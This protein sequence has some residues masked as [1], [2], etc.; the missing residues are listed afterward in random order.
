MDN[1]NPSENEYR[2]VCSYKDCT[3]IFYTKR[4]AKYCG[5]CKKIHETEQSRVRNA[6]KRSADAK[7]Q[8]EQ[9]K[10]PKMKMIPM[11]MASLKNLS[12]ICKALIIETVDDE[13][14]CS[15]FVDHAHQVNSS[16][17]MQRNDKVW[18]TLHNASQNWSLFGNQ[19]RYRA[20]LPNKQY[21]IFDNLYTR[22]TEVTSLAK[23]LREYCV[24][25][26]LGQPR[27]WNAHWAHVK[28]NKEGNLGDR[29]YYSASLETHKYK[30]WLS[31]FEDKFIEPILA[32]YPRHE[33]YRVTPMYSMGRNRNPSAMQQGLLLYDLFNYLFLITT[34]AWHS[35]F[36][37]NGQ[38]RIPGLTLG[39]GWVLAIEEGTFIH[40]R[41]NG[42]ES[43]IH[44]PVGHIFLFSGDLLHGGALYIDSNIR[45]HGYF[46]TR[47]YDMENLYTHW[48]LRDDD[49]NDEDEED[50]NSK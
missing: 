3:E 18:A 29:Y 4:A 23:H 37:Q 31:R 35:D 30:S 15:Q 11:Y 20:W 47:E 21:I 40:V 5:S 24:K 16:S 14:F 32:Y 12:I 26:H 22:V 7:E 9:E 27:A 19:A 39:M 25:P 42:V 2:N 38:P 44:L 36:D 34:T 8:A 45:I 48:S 43:K 13:E 1:P 41:Q 28:E 6:N 49:V 46:A 50:E 10:I 17:F 33:S